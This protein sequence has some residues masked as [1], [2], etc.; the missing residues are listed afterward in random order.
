MNK[1]S[2]KISYEMK[3]L[4]INMKLTFS[5]FDDLQ[6][7]TDC[8]NAYNNPG[9]SDNVNT[10]EISYINK[11]TYLIIEIEEKFPLPVNKLKSALKTI[12]FSMRNEIEEA[13]NIDKSLIEET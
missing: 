11:I 8:H 13:F 4:I 12:R 1:K 7:L 6:R 3:Q 10:E 2:N 9:I 5:E